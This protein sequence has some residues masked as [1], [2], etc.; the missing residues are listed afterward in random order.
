VLLR[1]RAPWRAAAPRSARLTT[2]PALL[3]GEDLLRAATQKRSA[4]KRARIKRAALE[5][6]GKRGYEGTAI[7]AIAERAG[8]AV[9]G[10]Y[11]HFRSKRQLLLTLMDELLEALSRLDMSPAGG[12]DMRTRLHGMLARAFAHDLHYLGAYRA[13]QEALLSDRDLAA[14]QQ[15][16]QAWTVNRVTSVLSLLQKAP[17]ARQIVDLQGIAR[18]IDSFFWSLLTQAMHMPKPDL[19]RALDAATHIIYHA[20]FVDPP[21]ATIKGRRKR[22]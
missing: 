19:D 9:G 17:G 12:S 4:D 3:D 18:V 14:K 13:W 2:R 15:L 6:F 11:Q 10:F 16:I 20:M 22:S 8:I 5:L 1:R 21:S 7:D